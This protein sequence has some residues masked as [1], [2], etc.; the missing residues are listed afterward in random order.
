MENLENNN[1]LDIR[2]NNIDI[3]NNT[4]INIE[5]KIHNTLI[6]N[7]KNIEIEENNNL[8]SLQKIEKRS[9]GINHT[10]MNILNSD[11]DDKE[12]RFKSKQIFNLNNQTNEKKNFTK[13][14]NSFLD[15]EIPKELTKI[16]N[17]KIVKK[18]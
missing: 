3:F 14:N 6:V 5:N 13:L 18:E 17:L 8:N 9:I 16:N 15:F 4:Y 12:I 7:E 11:N 1:I 2:K 10:S